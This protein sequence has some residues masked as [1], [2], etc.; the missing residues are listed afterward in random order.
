[1]GRLQKPVVATRQDRIVGVFSAGRADQIARELQN[2]KPV[3]GNVVEERLD[4]PVTL[5]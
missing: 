3:E 2:G 4:D 5:G 1:V